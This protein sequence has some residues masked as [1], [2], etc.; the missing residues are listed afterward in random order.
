M[1]IR[2]IDRI[3]GDKYYDKLPTGPPADNGRLWSR[4]HY[5]TYESY[6]YP[7]SRHP[8]GVNVAFC[9]GN[10][11]FMRE[12][13]D[14]LVY[15]QLMTSQQQAVD[16]RG[17]QLAARSRPQA[18]RSHR[19]ISTANDRGLR[20]I[21]WLGRLYVLQIVARVR[22]VNRHVVFR[23]EIADDAGPLDPKTSRE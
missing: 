13:I 2:T 7:S 8:G 10:I 20:S 16:A 3:N 11:E 19:M 15:A 22:F 17:C 4:Y 23:D 14:P 12:A 1:H 6:A 21:Q 5:S 9:G 18:A